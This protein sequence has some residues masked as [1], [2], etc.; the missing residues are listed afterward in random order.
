M[1]HKGKCQIDFYKVFFTVASI[2]G[3]K[4]GYI[5]FLLLISAAL[6]EFF[7]QEKNSKMANELAKVIC[8][9]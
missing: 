1:W 5:T 6:L 2:S 4:L 8:Q 7:E 3:F 9:A